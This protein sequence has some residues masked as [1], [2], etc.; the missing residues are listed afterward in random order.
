MNSCLVQNSYKITYTIAH[1]LKKVY[2]HKGPSEE[3]EGPV[4]HSIC[5]SCCSLFVDLVQL[6]L[7]VF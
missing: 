2:E 7:A 4:T 5:F 6:L 3:T 1:I